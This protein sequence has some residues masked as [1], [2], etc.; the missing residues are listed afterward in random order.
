MGLALFPAYRLEGW[1]ER[2]FVFSVRGDSSALEQPCFPGTGLI[3]ARM[4]LS[5][6]SDGEKNE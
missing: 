1:G 5:G 3:R 6:R 4:G 2:V